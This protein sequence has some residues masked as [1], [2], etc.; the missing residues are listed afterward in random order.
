MGLPRADYETIV[1]EAHARGAQVDGSRPQSPK[2]T[3]EE[4]QPIHSF[5]TLLEELTGIVR[6]SCRTPGSTDP[7]ATFQVTT[8]ANPVQQRALDLAAQIK[9]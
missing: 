4:D 2:L 6:S 3:A 8:T 1:R 9:V 7:D 5:Q